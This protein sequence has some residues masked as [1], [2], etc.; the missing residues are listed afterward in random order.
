MSG[1]QT[2]VAFETRQTSRF[3]LNPTADPAQPAFKGFAADKFR[4]EN[5]EKRF[6]ARPIRLHGSYK[7]TRFSYKTLICRR[8]IQ[9]HHPNRLCLD[10]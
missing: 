6:Y 9:A 8:Q 5:E 2:T 7:L 3:R 10:G 1:R 4:T